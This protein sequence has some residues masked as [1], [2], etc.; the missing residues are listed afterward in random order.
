MFRDA[1]LELAEHHA[2]ARPLVNSG[3]LSLPAIYDGSPLN[4]PNC[5]GMPA[6]TRPGAP[7]SDAPVTGVWLLDRLGNGFQLVTIDA[8]APDRLEIDGIAIERVA[9]SAGDDPTGALRDRYLGAA[10]SAVYLMRPDQHVAARW[11]SYDADAV[12]EALRVAT[13]RSA[14]QAQTGARN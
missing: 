12:A 3:R 2:F 8:Q 5:M 10:T 11:P 7:A 4:G 13:G 1:V 14:P 6:R 9:L